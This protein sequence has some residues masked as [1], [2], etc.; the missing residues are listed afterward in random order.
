MRQ[1]SLKVLRDAPVKIVPEGNPVVIQNVGASS[2]RVFF[3]DS[4]GVG[5]ILT[6]NDAIKANCSVCTVS[7]PLESA[8]IT[9]LEG[10]VNV[11]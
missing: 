9:V 1:Y 2:I 7:T 5:F 8:D 3:D 6:P 4:E 11:Y 10:D